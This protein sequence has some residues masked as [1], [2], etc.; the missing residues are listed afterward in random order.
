[1]TD[2]HRQTD[3]RRV[4]IVAADGGS[5]DDTD[6]T[7][8]GLHRSL[9]PAADVAYNN[10]DILPKWTGAV[11]HTTAADAADAARRSQ[12]ITNHLRSGKRSGDN[13]TMK[14][15]RRQ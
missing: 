3:D 6:A 4:E 11:P 1:M 8:G 5:D 15:C 12:P 7:T 14:T 2:Q 13:D 10:A 9:K